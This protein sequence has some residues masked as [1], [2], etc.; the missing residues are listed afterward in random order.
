MVASLSLSLSSSSSVDSAASTELIPNSSVRTLGTTFAVATGAAEA[1]AAVDD[2]GTADVGLFT[3]VGGADL[4]PGVA[5][6]LD[7]V[8]WEKKRRQRKSE[9]VVS[10]TVVSTVRRQSEASHRISSS[11]RT[12]R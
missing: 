11:C 1:G 8:V 5:R 6:K 3:A 9:T 4:G 2:A 10:V 7:G 12:L